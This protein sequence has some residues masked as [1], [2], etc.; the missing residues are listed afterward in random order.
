MH[1]FKELRIWQQAM[2]IARFS[3]QITKEFPREEV[4]GLTSQMKISSVSI[5]SNIAEG[6]GRGTNAQ[7]IHFLDI[8]IGS[9]CELETQ[10]ILDK[11]F[12]FCSKEKFDQWTSQVNSFQRQTRV[13]RERLAKNNFEDVGK[14][15]IDVGYWTLDYVK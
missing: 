1:N 13:F 9:S 8:S 12:D 14:W 10:I 3:Y 6:C 11:D 5:P 7:L 15:M 4:F 2:D